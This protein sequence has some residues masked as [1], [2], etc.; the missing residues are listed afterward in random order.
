MRN[1]VSIAFKILLVICTA[2]IFSSCSSKDVI[3][4]G[5]N[6]IAHS[7]M[8]AIYEREGYDEIIITNPKGNTVAHYAL[9]NRDE[10]VPSE[11]GEDV[12]KIHVPVESIVIDSEVYASILDELKMDEK[13]KGVFDA[14]YITIPKFKDKIQNGEIKNLGT[15]ASPNIEKLIGLQPD[16]IL[17]SYFE[18]MDVKG[19][20]KIHTPIIKMYDLQENKPL[21]RAEWVKFLGKLT[22]SEEKAKDIFDK[23]EKT[24]ADLKS[25]AAEKFNS[26][27]KK[28]SV[29]TE[30]IYEGVWYVPGG[31]SYQANLIKDAGGT[32]FM[33]GNKET[34]SL[35]LP[36]E[37]VLE[38]GISSDIWLIKRFGNIT[39]TSLAEEDPIYQEFE[40]FKKG[41]IYVSD[42]SKSALFRETPFHPEKLLR[43]YIT[44]FSNDT[45]STLKYFKKIEN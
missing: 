38:K 37:K 12:I 23:V 31:D 20:D 3:T 10:D 24:Y 44:I 28:P 36:V 9:L 11:I 22:G 4:H 29:L 32:Y 17:I 18:G 41:N 1:C 43:D 26:N 16:I 35:N 34:G 25:E 8:L 14:N 13:I 40:S 5:R 39:K 45:A 21:G 6:E 27:G 33:D 19:L 2:V 15:P 42:T 7:E 30:T